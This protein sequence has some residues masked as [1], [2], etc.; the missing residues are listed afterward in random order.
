MVF[1]VVFFLIR[2]GFFN[3]LGV[4]VLELVVVFNLVDVED[5]GRDVEVEDEE[6]LFLSD[7]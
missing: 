5:E 6:F 1:V 4:F 7:V 3:G 2:Y